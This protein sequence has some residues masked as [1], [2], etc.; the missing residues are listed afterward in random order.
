MALVT[1]EE[2]RRNLWLTETDMADTDIAAEVAALTERASAI[3]VDYL[4]NPDH[5]WTDATAPEDVKAAVLLALTVL[6][7][8]RAENPLTEAVRAVLHRRRD[9][10]LA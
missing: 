2:A 5:G 3:I 10:A 1:L 4:K 6:Y 7:G 8:D 9:P